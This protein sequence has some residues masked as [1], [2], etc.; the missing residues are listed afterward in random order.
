M[1]LKWTLQSERTKS[2]QANKP[3]GSNYKTFC[4]TQNYDNGEKINGGQLLGERDE[5]IVYRRFL[6][7]WNHSVQ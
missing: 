5:K 3:Y 4:K 2:K 7:Q 6:G 1:N